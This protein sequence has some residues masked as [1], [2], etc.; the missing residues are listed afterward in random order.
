MVWRSNP[1]GSEIFRTHPDQLRGP[2]GLL[3]NGYRVVPVVKRPGRG[4]NHPLPSSADV[5]ERVEL[6]LYSPSGPSW[7]VL[8]W[9][10]PLPLFGVTT[11]QSCMRVASSILEGLNLSWLFIL[12]SE[13]VCWVTTHNAACCHNAA[14]RSVIFHH[15]TNPRCIS[16]LQKWTYFRRC[17]KNYICWWLLYQLPTSL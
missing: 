7:H 16:V 5:K 2:P 17:S 12:K 11:I 10:L 9:I 13:A 4:V 14:E 1:G 3:Y 8:G 15:L 6:Y